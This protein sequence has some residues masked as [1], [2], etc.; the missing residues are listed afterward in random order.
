MQV[1][2]ITEN[3]FVL[4]VG[5][6][7][8]W[9]MNE[10]EYLF[11]SFVLNSNRWALSIPNRQYY[12]T[13]SVFLS[14]TVTSQMDYSGFH[15]A[16]TLHVLPVS[17]FVFC[18]WLNLVPH[19]KDMQVNWQLWFTFR[20][21]YDCEC[22]DLVTCL[23][24]TRP[25]AQRHVGLAPGPQNYAKD[26]PSSSSVHYPY[27]PLLIHNHRLIFQHNIDDWSVLI[28]VK[29]FWS[30]HKYLWSGHTADPSS[31]AADK[32]KSWIEGKMSVIESVIL[33]KRIIWV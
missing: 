17:A 15:P 10:K 27:K 16:P 3:P 2:N 31:L 20:Y 11:K 24:G 33:S 4:E 32:P 21:E 25:L 18:G 30:D 7:E 5:V 8:K 13:T 28:S 6:T 29:Y 14:S 19:S 12:K 23:G 22:F 1:R 26:K 9:R